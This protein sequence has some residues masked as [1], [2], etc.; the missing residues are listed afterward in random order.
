MNKANQVIKLKVIVMP[1]VTV[2]INFISFS[3][4]VTKANKDNQVLC[5]TYHNW[6]YYFFKLD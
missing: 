1:K 3:R 5:T 4:T 6:L 2:F